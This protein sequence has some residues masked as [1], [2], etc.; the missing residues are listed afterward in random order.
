MAKKKYKC[1]KCTGT[2]IEIKVW[3]NPNFEDKPTVP[4]QLEDDQDLWCEDCQEHVELKI[5]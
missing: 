5:E 1:S 4:E 3:W 2:N